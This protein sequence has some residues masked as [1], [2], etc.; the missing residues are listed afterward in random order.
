MRQF[1]SHDKYMMR[2]L[3]LA[4]NGTGLVSPNPMVGAVIVNDGRII[5]EGWHRKY[6]LAHAE[7]MA[8]QSVAPDDRHLL[9][10][11]TLYVSLEPCSHHGKTPPCA[12]L[13]IRHQIPRVVVGVTDPYPEVSG[14]GIKR[15]INAGVDV[16]VGVMED[17]CRELNKHFFTCHLL[18]RPYITL[19][20][21]QTANGYI[22]ADFKAMYISG[23]LTRMLCHKLR[24]EHQ[25]IL[26]GRV[27]QEREHPQ[28][29]VRHWCGRDPVRVILGGGMS[30][31]GCL[32]ELFRNGV[33]SLLVE[34]GLRTHQS[35]IEKGFW[36]E[37]C[38]ETSPLLSPGG[39]PAP[40]IPAQALSVSRIEVDANTICLYK[41]PDPSGF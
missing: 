41:N 22:D 4:S 32:D 38:V 5:G 2:C 40:R 18:H 29:N 6:G 33:R 11:S 7:V 3:Q 19:K 39:T 8:L 20:W 14:R 28:L 27:T 17:A 34:G 25:A 10:D 16:T 30:V 12:D 26:V 13:I 37:I 9:R 35:F 24:A 15:L 23:S 36:D 21:A 31:S 1:S